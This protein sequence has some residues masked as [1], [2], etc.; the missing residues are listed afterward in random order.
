MNNAFDQNSM[1]D[2]LNFFE[3]RVFKELFINKNRQFISSMAEEHLK[4]NKDISIYQYYKLLVSLK[5][6]TLSERLWE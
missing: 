3:K 5:T 1:K 4:R 6:D 2:S